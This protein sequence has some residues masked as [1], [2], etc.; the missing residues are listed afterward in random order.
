LFQVRIFKRRRNRLAALIDVS[1]TD[2]VGLP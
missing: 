1:S 2:P